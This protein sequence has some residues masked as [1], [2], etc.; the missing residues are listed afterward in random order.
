MSNLT[1]N[2]NKFKVDIEYFQYQVIEIDNY[3]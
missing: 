1:Q 2:T 3:F